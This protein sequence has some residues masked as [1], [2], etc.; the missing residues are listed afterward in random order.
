MLKT[1]HAVVLMAVVPHKQ[2]VEEFDSVFGQA[3]DPD[4]NRDFPMYRS[5]FIQRADVTADPSADPATLDWQDV[6]HKVLLD[7]WAKW[8]GVPQDILETSYLEYVDNSGSGLTYPLPP[9]VQ[10][11]L[12]EAMTHPDIPLASARGMPLPTSEEPGEE[13]AADEEGNKVPGRRVPGRGQRGPGFP[14]AGMMPGAGMPGMAGAGMAGGPGAGMPGAPG[15]GMPGMPGAEGG[16]AGMMPGMSGMAGMEMGMG[17]MGAGMMGMG[18]Q[19]RGPQVKYKLIRFTDL[20]VQPGHKYRYKVQVLLD[21]PNNHEVYP[22]PKP[23][24]LDPDVSARIQKDPEK[25]WRESDWSLPSEVVSVTSTQ[26]FY[27]GKVIPDALQEHVKGT[28]MVRQREATATALAVVHDPSKGVDVPVL[29][30]VIDQKDQR[31]IRGSTLNYKIDARV[32]HPVAGDFRK[33]KDYVL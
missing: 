20:T 6:S 19:G 15:A 9:F 16:E 17:G 10:R 2:Q 4:S 11:D 5:F 8:A 33:L 12:W 22:S 24:A 13:P 28:R 1:R 31:V 29:F 18:M 30:D 14:G 26:W 3:L 21:D 25:T 32:V 7:D 27:A 23:A